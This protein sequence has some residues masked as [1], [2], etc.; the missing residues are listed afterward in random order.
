[1]FTTAVAQAEILYGIGLLPDGRRKSEL[2]AAVKAMFNEDLEGRVLPFDRAAADAYAAVAVA[3]RHA[4]RPIP[5]FDAQIAA[6]CLSRDAVLATR[7][8][9]DFTGCGLEVRNPWNG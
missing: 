3:R 1:M 4:G 9:A 5:Q 2:E 6:I 7:N 8:T